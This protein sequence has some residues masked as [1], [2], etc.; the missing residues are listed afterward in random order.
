MAEY[1][2]AIDAARVRSPA[3]ATMPLHLKG[4]S[5]TPEQRSCAATA[6]GRQDQQQVSDQYARKME[7]L[8][9][10]HD[11]EFCERSRG[12]IYAALLSPLFFSLLA[13]AA[14]N[15]KKCTANRPLGESRA[16]YINP[17]LLSHGVGAGAPWVLE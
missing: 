13:A 2:V 6:A 5:Q 8:I 11:Y 10:P 12:L 17:L 9:F 7:T 15:R 1:I 4:G 3:D 14:K 16:A